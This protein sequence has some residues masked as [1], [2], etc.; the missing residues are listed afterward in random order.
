M[1]SIDS[2][3]IDV[4]IASSVTNSGTLRGLVG[5]IILTGFRNVDWLYTALQDGLSVFEDI[6]NWSFS[7]SDVRSRVSSSAEQHIQV[8]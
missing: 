3:N 8:G 6:L 4:I 5:R 2:A 1:A 7:M